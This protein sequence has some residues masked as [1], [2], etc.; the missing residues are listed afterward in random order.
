MLQ[1]TNY[2]S[3]HIITVYLRKLLIAFCAFNQ[4]CR[5]T[6]L[7]QTRQTQ[8]D[9]GGMLRYTPISATHGPLLKCLK[10]NSSAR[11]AVV[12]KSIQ[13]QPTVSLAKQI[14]THQ[15]AKQWATRQLQSIST[16]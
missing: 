8:T 6:R 5:H 4:F 2:R 7:E 12:V 13:W 15:W 11:N 10:L 14:A 1:T 3:A 9:F 16:L